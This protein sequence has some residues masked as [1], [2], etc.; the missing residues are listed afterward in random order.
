MFVSVVDPGQQAVMVDLHFFVLQG[1]CHGLLDRQVAEAEDARLGGREDEMDTMSPHAETEQRL[2][3]GEN[4]DAVSIDD[5]VVWKEGRNNFCNHLLCSVFF[6]FLTPAKKI[7][8]K[9]I[10]TSG[11]LTFV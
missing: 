10:K 8:K 2:H 1:C 6:S 11:S 7:N 9:K 3:G 5:G 4:I